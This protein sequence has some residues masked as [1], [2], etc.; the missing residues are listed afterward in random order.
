MNDLFQLAYSVFNNRDVAQKAEHAQRNM[1]KAQMIDSGATFSFLTQKNGNPSNHKEYVMGVSGK[2]QGHT[3]VEPLLCKI[4]GQLFLHSFL[5]A[6]DCPIPLMERDLL[7]KLGAT[8]FLKGQGNHPH[9]QMVLT[10]SGKE[11]IKSEAKTEGLVDPG[12]WNIEVL[13]LDEGI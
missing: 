10:E 7:I 6:P 11:Q 9:N 5:F 8:L 2:M 4:N 3:F 1:Q 13:G 12:M